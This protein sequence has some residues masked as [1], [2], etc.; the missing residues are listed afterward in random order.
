MSLGRL[1]FSCFLWACMAQQKAHRRS[2]TQAQAV[3]TSSCPHV[4]QLKQ[5]LA[6][7]H[8]QNLATLFPHTQ[9]PRAAMTACGTSG[10]THNM[11][12]ANSI[13]ADQSIQLHGLQCASEGVSP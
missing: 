13:V 3:C 11:A 6:A 4:K 7:P 2:D 10:Q 9:K 12:T 8:D 1:D 5:P